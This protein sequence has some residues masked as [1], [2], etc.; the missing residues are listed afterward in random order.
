MADSIQGID[1]RLLFRETFES[2]QSVRRNGGTPTGVT[3][4][5]GAVLFG[6]TTPQISVSNNGYNG[7]VSIRMI[8]TS[9]SFTAGHKQLF[10]SSGVGTTIYLSNGTGNI[11]TSSG[12]SYINGVS[13]S[14]VTANVRQDIIITNVTVKGR[15]FIIG[16]NGVSNYFV[17][18]SIE[19]F[20]IYQGTLTAQEV[21]NLYNN[22]RYREVSGHEEQLGAELVVN[23]GFDT[24][25]GWTKQ[26]SWTISGG[27]ANYDDLAIHYIKQNLSITTN[28]VYKLQVT[29]SGLTSGTISLV[30]CNAAGASIMLSPG[31]YLNMV[32]GSYEYKFI[33]AL[34][35]SE[36][37]IYGNT[38]SGSSFSI[39]NLSIKEVLVESVKPILDVCACNGVVKN[40]YSGDVYGNEVT[41][42]WNT[43]SWWTT[44]QAG[45]TFNEGVSATC[46]SGSPVLYK[47]AGWTNGKKYRIIMTISV[48]SGSVTLP[49]DGISGQTY[50]S[51]SGT[52]TVDYTTGDGKLYIHTI[53]FVGSITALSI[54]EIIP[55]VTPTAI[56]Y[57][58][59][60]EVNAMEFNGSTSKIDCGSYDGLVG[61]KTFVAWVNYNSLG[62]TGS[63]KRILENGK[64]LKIVDYTQRKI[65][66]SS[67]GGVTVVYSANDSTN[68]KKY[69]YC[70]VITR[71]N[72]GIANIYV[73]GVLSGTANQSSGT[74]A[75]GTT[76]II[77]GYNSVAGKQ[78]YGK[79]DKIRIY[80][81][82]LSQEEISRIYSQEK[83][84]YAQ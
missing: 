65:G 63:N 80:D 55:S 82:I 26:S 52:Y 27:K 76:N 32:N 46:S 68:Y 33:A 4:S 53:L 54:K 24:D 18:S 78:W 31:G 49:W 37:Y 6:S 58:K 2:E 35:T 64:I 8:C 72:T 74:P 73:N 11:I 5:N 38:A 62:S 36:L 1:K 29:T 22:S 30:F 57:R 20:E 12:T 14:T 13:S 25:S 3:F 23:G 77:I 15:T 81:G 70:I 19:L 42:L 47:A 44:V 40:K 75:I 7:S 69:W 83:S 48:T 67:D 17:N 41:P 21:S 71:A 45:W 79:I 56:T 66:F 84:K 59:E 50:K 28:R 60:N 16:S 51:S 43:S 39:D 10:Y 34:T 9:P 61:D